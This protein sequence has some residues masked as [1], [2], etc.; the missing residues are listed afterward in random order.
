MRQLFVVLA[1]AIVFTPRFALTSG[2]EALRAADSPLQAGSLPTPESATAT[3]VVPTPSPLVALGLLAAF[4]QWRVASG[5]SSALTTTASAL[6][7]ATHDHWSAWQSN[8]HALNIFPTLG[9]KRACVVQPHRRA[10]PRNIL[11]S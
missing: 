6:A 11:Q 3:S 9:N 1:A 10:P 5:S 8:G 2:Q 4:S 7:G